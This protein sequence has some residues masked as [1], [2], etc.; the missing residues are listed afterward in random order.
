M[1]RALLACG[2]LS[3]LV[4]AGA[5]LA[6]GLR[7]EGYSF[8]DQTISELGA[9]GAPSRPLFSVLLIVVYVLLTAFGVG[10]WRSAGDRRSFRVYSIVTILAV[11]GFGG[12]SAMEIS[13]VGQ[14][15]A[16]PW[17]GVK[18][19]VFWYAYELW[20]AVLAFRLLRE[21]PSTARSVQP[22]DS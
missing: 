21:R 14:G 15:L 2:V 1:R 3:P 9:I 10:V 17:V 19:R 18:E 20:F 8:R 4:Y 16:T 22:P 7:W 12:W 6:A 5:D 11:L 13:R